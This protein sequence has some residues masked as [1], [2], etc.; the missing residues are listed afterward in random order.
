M[1]SEGI[2]MLNLAFTLETR[3]SVARC[4]RKIFLFGFF[5]QTEDVLRH[6]IGLIADFRPEGLSR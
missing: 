2:D 1:T 3:Q 5:C 4:T 6:F